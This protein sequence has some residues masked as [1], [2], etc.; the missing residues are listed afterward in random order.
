MIAGDAIY[1]KDILDLANGGANFEAIEVGGVRDWVNPEDETE[2]MA[3]R[4]DSDPEYYGVWLKYVGG[5][6]DCVADFVLLSSA[7]AYAETLKQQYGWP[8]YEM[9]S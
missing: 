4:D 2:V 5:G 7:I 6:L 8:I 1:L 3:E 9:V